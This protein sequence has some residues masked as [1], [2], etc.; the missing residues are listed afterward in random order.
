MES[1]VTTYLGE[2]RD[3]TGTLVII[4][5]RGGADGLNM[6]IPHGDDRYHA[7][8]PGLA[9]KRPDL[10]DLDGFFGLNHPNLLACL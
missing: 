10:I 1:P 7:A 6:V 3:A 5:L 8:R 2:P 9:I 4:F